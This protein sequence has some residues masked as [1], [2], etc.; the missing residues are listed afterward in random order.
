M[1]K[2]KTAV[3]VIP[4]ATGGAA[5]SPVMK[6]LWKLKEQTWLQVFALL[7]IIYIILFNFVPMYGILMAFKSYKL[8]MGISG[9][10]T[11]EWVGLKH[12]RT[13]F[14]EYLFSQ[15][16]R[17]TLV[18]SVLK[19]IFCFPMP[20]L[21][22][23]MLHEMSNRKYKKFV[24]TVSYM[25]HFISWV[26]CVGIAN[27]LFS[28]ELGVVQGILENLGIGKIPLLTSPDYFWGFSVV[29][30]I[31]KSSGWWAII[32]LA[33]ITG[34]DPM[35]YEAAIVDGAGRLKRIWHITIPGMRG[36]IVT[37]LILSIGSFL[38]G[39]MVGSNFEQSYLFGNAL[40]YD[41]SKIIQVYSF[42]V[43][44]KNGQVA[45]ATAISVVES[46]CSLVLI[47]TSNFI[48]KKI[49]GSGLF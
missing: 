5:I 20:I 44:L 39:G 43:G 25:P 30:S 18:L 7:G 10:F 47:F 34:I 3:S 14:N 38:G 42:E 46:L 32:F 26:V 31:W 11:A 40:N 15:L 35:L 12:F 29:A 37:M 21:L 1:R 28:S 49:A 24:Q 2:P 22:A 16:L 45:Y 33:A 48:S 13:F 6:F 27:A 17:N 4:N 8:N 41:T 9:I 36:A 23:I 19:L